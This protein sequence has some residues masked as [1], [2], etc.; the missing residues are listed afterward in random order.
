MKCVMRG[1]EIEPVPYKVIRFTVYF[2][3]SSGNEM[4]QESV[5]IWMP[6]E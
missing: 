1:M 2:E 5:A 4:P 3:S 6:T